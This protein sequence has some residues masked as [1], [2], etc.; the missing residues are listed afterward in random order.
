MKTDEFKQRPW[1]AHSLLSGVPLRTLERVELR[2][3]RPGMTL[4]EI[5]SVAG[6]GGELGME[7]GAMTRALFWLRGLIGRILGWD[8]APKLVTAVS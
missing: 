5:S 4:A 7:V 8:E 3:G 2:G 1:R 6:F